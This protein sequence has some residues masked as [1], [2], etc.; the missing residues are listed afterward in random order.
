MAEPSTRSGRKKSASNKSA[1]NKSASRPANKSASKKSS[2][3]ST[4]SRSA[5]RAPRSEAPRRANGV[6]IA[7]RAAE[8]L[9]QLTGREA[10]AIIGL[11]RNDEGWTVQVEVLEVR[12]IP[13]TT[14]VLA[15]YEIDASAEGALQGYRRLG[16]LRPGI[17]GEGRA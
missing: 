3:A 4:P 6:Q 2:S 1:S 17:P 7:S 5:T 13:S 10:E 8:E 14:D 16:A 15:L 9:H 12:R 11:S